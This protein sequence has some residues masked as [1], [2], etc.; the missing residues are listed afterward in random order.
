MWHHA[1]DRLPTDSTV[2]LDD[3]L[4]IILSLDK[5]DKELFKKATG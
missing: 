2:L 1:K 4:K 5:L 3:V